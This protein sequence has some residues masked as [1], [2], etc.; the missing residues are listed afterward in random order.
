MN[1]KESS[2]TS[3]YGVCLIA[4]TVLSYVLYHQGLKCPVCRFSNLNNSASTSG[5]NVVYR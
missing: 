5:I 4:D 1:L 3:Q 2:T